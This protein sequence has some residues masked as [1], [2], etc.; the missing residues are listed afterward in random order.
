MRGN[1]QFPTARHNVT[2]PFTRALS[3][4]I[5]YTICYDHYMNKTTNAHQLAMAA[6]YYNPLT[7]LYWYDAP[8][9]YRA[10]SW[11]AMQWFDECP[12]TWDETRAIGGEPG[13]YVAVARRCGNRWFLGAM[14]N[15]EARTIQIPLAFLGEGKW[16]AMVFADGSR[17]PEPRRTKVDIARREVDAA[18]ILTVAMQPSGGQA[19]LFERL[20]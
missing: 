9:K 19:I 17:A 14:T 4:P 11:P 18:A 10:G 15:E 20:T 12:T 3:G 2:L 16:Q 5:D 1:E 13:E 7:F 6:V 8:A